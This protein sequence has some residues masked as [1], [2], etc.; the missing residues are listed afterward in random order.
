MVND[1]EQ[2]YKIDFLRKKSVCDNI[3][4]FVKPHVPD[5]TEVDFQDIERVLGEPEYSRRGLISFHYV[6]FRDVE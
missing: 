4:S 2:K 6:T 3:V 5:V 1:E